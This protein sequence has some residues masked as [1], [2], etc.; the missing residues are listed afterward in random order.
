M[1]WEVFEP[2]PL[3]EAAALLICLVNSLQRISLSIAL[4]SNLLTFTVLDMRHSIVA[5][6][7]HLAIADLPFPGLG[8]W[9]G[10]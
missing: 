8:G 4:Q 10:G 2:N 5:T 7:Y 9:A 6:D 3:R 1:F